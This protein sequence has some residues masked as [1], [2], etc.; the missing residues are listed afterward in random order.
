M[1][2]S[3]IIV[4]LLI[5]FTVLIIVAVTSSKSSSKKKSAAPPKGAIRGTMAPPSAGTAPITPPPH[6]R[7]GVTAGGTKTV[8]PGGRTAAARPAQP[9]TNSVFLFNATRSVWRCPN[10][11][12]ENDPG[13]THCSVCFWDKT[14][15]VR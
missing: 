2:S 4:F 12:C 6:A 9:S 15:G 8:S 3:L 7:T 10:C 11:E 5:F 1:D 13:S 14:V